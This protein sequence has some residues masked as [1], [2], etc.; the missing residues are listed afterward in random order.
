V[1]WKQ[2]LNVDKLEA[3][4]PLGQVP[5]LVLDDG[6][7]LTQ[8]TAILEYLADRKPG[9]LLAEAGTYERAKAMS[10][11]AFVAA[12]LH[13]A[14]KPFFAGSK[15]TSSAPA[16][17]DMKNY[18]RG[19]IEK[20]L[21]HLDKNLAG[22]DYLMGSRFTV[23]DAYLFVVLGWCKFAEIPVAPYANVAASLRKTN[24]RPAVQRVLEKEGLQDYLPL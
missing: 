13:P 20:Y 19:T 12:D 2:N 17:N 6:G 14:F 10:W 16:V 15:M 22:K 5:A 4:N 9:S 8:N 18:A 3:V 21:K 11:T 24:A 7:I 1:S 23:A